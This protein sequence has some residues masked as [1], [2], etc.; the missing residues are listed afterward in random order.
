MDPP[1]MEEVA[2]LL[3]GRRD[4]S[5]FTERPALQKSTVVE[6]AGADVVA[7]GG[8]IRV[9]LTASHFLWK[10]VRRLVGPWS[11]WVRASGARTKSRDCRRG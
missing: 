6:L 4:H 5:A 8:L 9:R 3:L 11:G 1:R 7:D 10:M 2:R